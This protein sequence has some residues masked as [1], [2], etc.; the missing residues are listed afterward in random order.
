MRS[1]RRVRSVA[2][3]DL[4]HRVSCFLFLYLSFL[5]LSIPINDMHVISRIGKNWGTLICAQ[6]NSDLEQTRPDNEQTR[7]WTFE[8]PNLSS[9]TD[10]LIFWLWYL[11]YITIYYWFNTWLKLK[12]IVC[13]CLIHWNVVRQFVSFQMLLHTPRQYGRLLFLCVSDSAVGFTCFEPYRFYLWLLQG[14]NTNSS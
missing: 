1:V 4:A 8:G 7:P 5:P 14:K 3:W 13:M 12:F 11:G 6:T 10:A 9:P 2:T